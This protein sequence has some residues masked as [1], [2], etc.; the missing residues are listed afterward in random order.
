MEMFK[1][2]LICLI[3]KNAVIEAQWYIM[4]F[5]I[6]FVFMIIIICDDLLSAV[7]YI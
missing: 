4:Y 3:K 6:V 5:V 2:I 7:V 1:L